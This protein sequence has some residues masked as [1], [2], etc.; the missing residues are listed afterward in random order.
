MSSDPIE[1]AIFEL[2]RETNWAADVVEAKDGR[3]LIIRGGVATG[4]IV[5]PTGDRV[6]FPEPIMIEGLI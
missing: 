2:G 3:L 5:R 6:T 4:E 1:Q